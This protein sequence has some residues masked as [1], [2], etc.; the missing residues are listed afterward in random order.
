MVVRELDSSW[1]AQATDKITGFISQDQ[2]LNYT[3]AWVHEKS[4]QD[5][6]S[7]PPLIVGQ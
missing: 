6:K 3:D 5:I 7:N 1:S 4:I 2:A